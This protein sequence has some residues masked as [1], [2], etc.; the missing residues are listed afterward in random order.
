MALGISTNQTVA[1]LSQISDIANASSF[2]G[3]LVNIN[4]TVYSGFFFFIMLWVLAFIFYQAAN[5]VRDQPLNNAMYSLGVVSFIAFI[6]RA[7]GLLT[8]FQMW[9]FP[10]ITGI[11]AMIVWAIKRQ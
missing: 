2:P 7:I 10:I 5:Q 1:N 6:F 3:L 11:L 4:T 8:D 9:A